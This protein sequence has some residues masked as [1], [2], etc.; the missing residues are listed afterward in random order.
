MTAAGTGL[1]S[2]LRAQIERDGPMPLEAFWQAAQTSPEEGYYARGRPIG[3]GGDFTTAPEISQIFG[4][5]IGLWLVEAWTRAGEPT[6]CTLMELGPGRGQLMAD[7][8]RAARVAPKFLAA[9]RLVLVDASPTLQDAQEEM[10]GGFNPVWRDSWREAFAETDDA[11]L[12]LVANEFLDAL[13]IRQLRR[14]GDAWLE[15]LVAVGPD[16]GFAFTEGPA[17]DL[18]GAPLDAFQAAPD[19]AILEHS[20]ERQALSDAI[21]RRLSETDGAALLIDYGYGAPRLGDSLQALRTGKPADP[22]DAPGEADISA[23]VDFAAIIRAAEVAGA[24]AW[25]PID[26]GAFLLAL[27]AD[28]RA[29]A[30]T[31][32]ASPEAVH[33]IERGLKRLIHP[34]EM[35]GLFKAIALMP[36]IYPPPAGFE[37]E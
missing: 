28:G 27:G 37:Q 20:A 21:G 18:S 22:L 7:A 26:Q 10:L 9:A 17:C 31:R 3:A 32:S 8:L 36:A 33:V 30:L 29:A 14:R 1:A 35:G 23:H 12:F 24:R 13:P 6:K 16:G 2:R 11:P 19:G 34:L 5:L 15:R 4:E 25:G